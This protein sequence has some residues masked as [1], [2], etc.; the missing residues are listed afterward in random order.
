MQN[1]S[2][3][4]KRSASDVLA[5]DKRHRN[6]HNEDDKGQDGDQE[7]VGKTSHLEEVLTR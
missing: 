4:K 3:N 1:D 6:S 5:R 7:R 2:P